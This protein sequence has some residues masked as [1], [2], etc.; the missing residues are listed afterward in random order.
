MKISNTFFYRISVLFSLAILFPAFALA[1]CMGERYTLTELLN[2]PKDGLAIFICRV[3]STVMR[4]DDGYCSYATLKEV[5]RGEN[6]QQKVRILTGGNTSAGGQR[7]QEGE[8]FLIFSSSRDGGYTYSGFVCDAFS[9]QISYKGLAQDEPSL[10]IVRKYYE[11]QKAEYSGKVSFEW[12]GK[13]LAE[14]RFKKGKPSGD[15]KHYSLYYRNEGLKPLPLWSEVSYAAGLLHGTC[16]FYQRYSKGQKIARIETY[17]KGKLVSGEYYSVRENEYYK[18]EDLLNYQGSDGKSYTYRKSYYA[19]AMPREEVTFVN[20]GIPRDIG[21][22]ISEYNEGPFKSYHEN[23]LLKE[24][25]QYHLGAKVGT[26]LQYSKEGALLKEKHYSRPDSTIAA[27]VVFHPEGGVKV[28]GQLQNGKPEGRWIGYREQ[29]GNTFYTRIFKNGLLH[30]KSKT[31]HY[32]KNTLWKEEDYIA[33]KLHGEE[34]QYFEDGTTLSS[35][36][37]YQDGKKHGEHKEWHSLGKLRVS[38][39]YKDNELDGEFIR[40]SKDGIATE[41]GNY[42]NGYKQG[43]FEEIEMGKYLQKGEYYYGQRVGTWQHF[44]PSGKLSEEYQYEE[45][46]AV[47]PGERPHIIKSVYYNE[48]GSI[49]QSFPNKKN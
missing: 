43:F 13:T 2:T 32:K 17:D 4:P 7:L 23:G 31:Y 26:W 33:G 21:V 12:E 28:L 42:Q 36:T 6:I 1:C 34:K 15:W 46:S 20:T 48:D 14:G 29:D 25:G 19:G 22:I 18:Y 35:L 49:K 16:R 44:Y 24:Q 5:F 3:D 10:Q 37:Q 41:K 9:R 45:K 38:A 40:Y 30:G 27:F 39:F 8:E 47:A 11:L